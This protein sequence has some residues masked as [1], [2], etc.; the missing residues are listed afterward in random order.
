MGLLK[1]FTPMARTPLVAFFNIHTMEGKMKD[2]TL[3]TCAAGSVGRKVVNILEAQGKRVRAGVHRIERA[4]KVKEQ[5]TDIVAL[6]FSDSRSIETAVT[7][8]EQVCL[9]TPHTNKQVEWASLLIDRAKE[10]GVKRIVRLSGLAA[11]MGPEVQVGRWMSTV[12]NYLAESGLE[13]TVIRPS[14]FMQNFLTLYPKKDRHYWP[15]IGDG[16][17]C[18]IDISDVAEIL[19]KVLTEG[20]HNRKTYTI[21]GSQPLSMTEATEILAQASHTSIA[22][23]PI[24]LEKTE[25]PEWLIDVLMQL[26]AAFRSGAASLSV[27]TVEKMLGRAPVSF[28]QFAENQGVFR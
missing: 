11:A 10:A 18:H 26:F 14:P 9:I 27:D 7:G 6:D 1:Y 13:W 24:P 8:V 17:I 12:E 22:Y 15:P 21:T 28:E 2:T 20:G 4:P 25:K 3:I 5:V 23:N 19:A 16:K